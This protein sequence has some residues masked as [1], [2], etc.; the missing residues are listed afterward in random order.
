MADQ[1]H[2][3][4]LEGIKLPQRELPVQ[5]FAA[6]NKPGEPGELAVALQGLTIL[7]LKCEHIAVESLLQSPQQFDQRIAVR[8]DLEEF[9]RSLVELA[10]VV[11]QENAALL[12]VSDEQGQN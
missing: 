10:E 7:W 11:G 3:Q 6:L 2:R 4:I 1:F 12:Q 9:R 5:L 8:Q